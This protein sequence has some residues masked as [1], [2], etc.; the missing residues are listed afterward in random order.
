[1]DIVDLKFYTG[2]EILA[3]LVSDEGDT[4]TVKHAVYV[5]PIPDQPSEVKLVPYLQYGS[6]DQVLTLPKSKF[7]M[8]KPHAGLI[9]M[10]NTKFSTIVQPKSAVSKLILS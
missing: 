9:D 1:M 2:D 10:M 4:I 7:V 6:A 5:M 8:G 3:E